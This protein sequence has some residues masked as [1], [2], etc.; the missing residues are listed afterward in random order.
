MQ[1]PAD[2]VVLLQNPH[3]NKNGAEYK[4]KGKKGIYVKCP[5]PLRRK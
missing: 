4:P 5:I 1:K 2:G 3:L